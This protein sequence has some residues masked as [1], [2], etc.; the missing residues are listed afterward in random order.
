MS[1]YVSACINEA[2]KGAVVGGVAGAVAGVMAA[3][4]GVIPGAITGAA[5]GAAGGCIQGILNHRETTL[6]LDPSLHPAASSS[7]SSLPSATY[8]QMGG[9]NVALFTIRI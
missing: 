2:N 3:G 9:G 1:G 6:R 7:S 5:A 4:G 8:R